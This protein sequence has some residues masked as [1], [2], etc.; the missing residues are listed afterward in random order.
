MPQQ[1]AKEFPAD[2]IAAR[3]HITFHRHPI[4]QPLVRPIPV[5]VPHELI[6]DPV[7]VP[8][9]EHHEVIQALLSQ[10]LDETLD[11]GIQVG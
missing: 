1:S 6:D 2:D 11:E 9:P 3:H 10:R 8:F 4:P 7:Q 5:V